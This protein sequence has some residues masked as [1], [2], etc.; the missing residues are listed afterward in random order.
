M[1][2]APCRRGIGALPTMPSVR[3]RTRNPR[4]GSSSRLSRD[5]VRDRDPSFDQVV[6]WA[7]SPTA[8]ESTSLSGRLAAAAARA[9]T[10]DGQQIAVKLG[11][12]APSA[13]PSPR[14]RRRHD[15]RWR[16]AA[17]N[18]VWLRSASWFGRRRGGAWSG[19]RRAAPGGGQL[20]GHTDALGVGPSTASIHC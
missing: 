7:A 10:V 15:Y 18:V 20:T 8:C 12:R 11:Y 14:R 19:R 2:S 4:S 1:T 13:V 6:N 9:V 3:S 16:P 5:E 17:L